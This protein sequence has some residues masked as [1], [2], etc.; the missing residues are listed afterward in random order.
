M[1]YKIRHLLFL[2]TILLL[3]T[4]SAYSQFEWSH[5]ELD[6]ESFETEHFVI[7]FHQGTKRTAFI[8][9]KI[10]EEI[11]H[12]VT[13]LYD[14]KPADKIH[15]II[16][17]TDD[18]S[19]GAAYFFD[20]KMEVWASNL[21]YIMRG[22][23]NW[24]RD[25][26]T[27]EFIHMIS[28][29]KTI[30]TNLNFP[31]GFLQW[32]GY[33]KERRK[34]VV[35]GFPNTLVVYPLSSIDMPVWFAEGVAQYQVD[36]ARFDYRD[37]HREMIIRDRILN[38]QMLTYNE[39]SVFGKTSHGNES[40]YNLGFSFTKYLAQRFGEKV[41][42]DITAQSAKWSN[43]TFNN[44][45][46]KATGVKA[47][48]LYKN[49][50]DSLTTLYNSKTEIIRANEIKG[51]VIEKDG[52]ANLY[53][54]FS[55]DGQKIAYTS[56][57]DQ[58]YFNPTQLI[59]Y[60]RTSQ[61]KEIIARGVT[62]SISWSPDSHKIAYARKEPSENL[63]NF[64][65]IYIYD[66]K[67]EKEYQLTHNMRADNPDF[68]R[69]GKKLA[70][71]TTA[72]GLHQLNLLYL[73]DSPEGKMQGEMYFNVETGEMGNTNPDDKLFRKAKFIP[74]EIKQLIAFKDGRQIYHPRWA[75]GDRQIV[76][77]TSTSYGRDIAVFDF[78]SQE[79]K[80][81]INGPE[82]ER[83]PVFQ[84]G[85]DWL[86]YSAGTT[87]IYNLYRYN[88]KTEEKQLLTNVTGGA[89]M[90]SVA[91]NGDI[92][93]ACYD[94]IGYKIYLL[95]NPQAADKNL[96]VYNPDYISAI[97]KK[98]FDDSDYTNYQSKPYKT[99]YLKTHILPRVYIDYNTIKPGFFIASSDVLNKLNLFTGAAIN[100]D[101]DYDLYFYANYLELG[102][103]LFAE[104]FN[105][106]ANIQDTL[107][108][109]RGWVVKA[110]QNINFNL[111][112]FRSGVSLNFS[113]NFLVSLAYIYSLYKAKLD[114]LAF[115]TPEGLFD[116]PT[117]RYDYLRGHAAEG[118][119]I[120]N[121]LR[122]DRFMNIS[123]SGGYF[124]YGRFTHESNNFIKGFN[125]SGEE[126]LG[127]EEFN[128]Y[129]YNTFELN[130][131]YY[132]KNPL[133]KSHALGVQLKSG[134]I[135]RKVNSFF[136]FFAGG[137]LGLKGYSF[138]SIEGRNKLIGSITYRFPL[139][140]N[141]DMKLGH[142]HFDKL[143]MGA[144]YEYGDAFD[145]SIDF[146]DFK[147][148][149]GVELRLESFSYN[150]FPTRMFFQA[151]WPIDNINS[152]DDSREIFVNNPQEW[153]FY[154]GILFDFDLRERMGS[155]IS[156]PFAAG[157]GI[158]KW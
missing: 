34:D 143:F 46:H 22:T 120:Y 71:V 107:E 134:I 23:K 52:F 131:E 65:D 53:P 121:A 140:S 86:Y 77:G 154:F 128:T 2:F 60:D 117:I 32:F 37:P 102:P 1:V 41:L 3:L 129:V 10:L 92:V 94:S 156:N 58:D 101:F 103:E 127:L 93:Y 91:E 148:D 14:Y 90:P 118:R 15:I 42:S 99:T 7:H 81:L 18:Y 28:I 130:G 84:P 141:L 147:R 59:I 104:V 109:D 9:A 158:N 152:F 48:T 12:P 51:N 123:P 24:L 35:R 155:F 25:V 80:L 150:L 108:I 39:M 43:Y 27:H 144:F 87:G 157:K 19:N 112:Q 153:R 76:F 79:F 11:F 125:T 82:E 133:I 67:K 13:D 114:P 126:S 88:L 83:Y 119:V 73:P 68:S 36:K 57:K 26:M 149:V 4:E 74:G 113:E 62:S 89:L 139:H 21:D 54:V 151:V 98:N 135:D 49:W 5:P 50:K 85:S 63:S 64:S 72:N 124:I 30:K 115:D 6:W 137:I 8:S 75:D 55:P 122:R 47:D 38:E 97:P 20:N 145:R 44:A 106:N 95:E 142:L 56:N 146:K 70:F 96:A 45:L 116:L 16:K 69:D 17:D 111:L 29:Q 40:S 33:E 100:N 110:K 61:K 31:Y 66:F 105:I 132:I 78:K 136:N 138:Y